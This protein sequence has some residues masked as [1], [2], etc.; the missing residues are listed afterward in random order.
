MNMLESLVSFF[1]REFRADIAKW[2]YGA[3]LQEENIE[4]VRPNSAEAK[5]KDECPIWSQKTHSRRGA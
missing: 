1:L 4:H 2:L 5:L 3:R